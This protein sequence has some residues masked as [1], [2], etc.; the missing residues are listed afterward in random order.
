MPGCARRC[1]GARARARARH[2]RR[3]DGVR[4]VP[5]RARRGEGARQAQGHARQR[6]ECTRGHPRSCSAAWHLD[7]AHL[8]RRAARGHH[9]APYARAHR[10]A[11]RSCDW[12]LLRNPATK[13]SLVAGL[14]RRAQAGVTAADTLIV[15]IC[16]AVDG[17]TS[18][19]WVGGRSLGAGLSRCQPLHPLCAQPRHHS[20]VRFARIREPRRSD[21]TANG[22]GKIA[23]LCGVRMKERYFCT[24]TKK[25]E[26][27]VFSP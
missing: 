15:R 23:D 2:A 9:A 8:R 13:K 20:A 3:G 1:E 11:L 18:Q 4:Q 26:K 17:Q 10:T 22:C 12:V 5:G 24:K 21:V 25:I 27:N 6:G 16:P 19:H 14:L 7:P